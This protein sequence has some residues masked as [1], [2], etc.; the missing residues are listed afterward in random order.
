M[1]TPPILLLLGAGSN[2]G[3]HVARSFAGKGYKIA[4]VSR[5]LKEE[6]STQDQINISADLS[7]PSSVAEVFSKVRARLGHPSVVVYNGRQ[8]KP[9]KTYVYKVTIPSC[10][11]N[12]QQRNG[13][14][15]TP[16]GRLHP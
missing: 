13:P 5:S 8:S 7:D 14:P 16:T 1:A 11:P 12:T 6:D 10:R 4:L 2:I 9:H 15:L 3:H